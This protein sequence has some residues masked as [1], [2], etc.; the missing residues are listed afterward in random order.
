MF[1]ISKNGKL[2]ILAGATP[3]ARILSTERPS[4]Q[5]ELVLACH[6]KILLL[7][8]STLCRVSLFNVRASFRFRLVAVS[9]SILLVSFSSIFHFHDEEVNKKTSKNSSFRFSFNHSSSIILETQKRENLSICCY[10]TV[11]STA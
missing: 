6:D 1:P 9:K 11:S 8:F 2:R 4:A 7:C 3:Q 5:Q 10:K